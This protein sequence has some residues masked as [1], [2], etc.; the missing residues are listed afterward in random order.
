MREGPTTHCPL[1]LIIIII[2]KV[3]I[4]SRASSRAFSDMAQWTVAQRA[5]LLMLSYYGDHRKV[6]EITAKMTTKEMRVL[7]KRSPEECV[8]T[9]GG[10]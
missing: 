10:S 3:D 2:I 7:L 5:V 9:N 8:L 4:S 1:A 6:G